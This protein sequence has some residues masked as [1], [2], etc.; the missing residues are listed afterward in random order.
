MNPSLHNET[1]NSRVP[2]VTHNLQPR[3]GYVAEAVLLSRERLNAQ[4]D[5]YSQQH[6]A[7]YRPTQSLIEFHFDPL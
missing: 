6:A 3:T 5:D 7:A 1:R 2:I 4:P